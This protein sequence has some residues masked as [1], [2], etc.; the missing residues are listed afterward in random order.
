MMIVVLHV[1]GKSV[2]PA[3]VM[4]RMNSQHFLTTNT[5]V[6][7]PRDFLTRSMKPEY[8]GFCTLHWR[9]HDSTA[10]RYKWS[11]SKLL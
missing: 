8:Q 10:K 11:T 5:R 6:I 7:P 1:E 2:L 9:L 3:T 4:T